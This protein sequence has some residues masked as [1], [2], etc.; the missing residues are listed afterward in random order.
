MSLDITPVTPE[1]RQVIQKYGDGGFQIAGIAYRSSVLVMAETSEPWDVT[2]PEMITPTSLA[3]FFQDGVG[4]DIMLIGCGPRFVA[5]PKGL[6]QSLKEQGAVLEWMDT[7]A[8]CRTFNVLLT[9]ERQ[10]VAALIA[11]Q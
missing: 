8:A 7:G 1:G 11:V 5:P 10:V 3:G 9:E 4:P 6:R 2:K